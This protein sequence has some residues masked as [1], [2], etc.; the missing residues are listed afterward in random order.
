M[1]TSV[2]L[3]V[4]TKIIVVALVFPLSMLALFLCLLILDGIAGWHFNKCS[5]FIVCVFEST[6]RI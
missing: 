4:T 5:T 6:S 2:F 1:N 3:R